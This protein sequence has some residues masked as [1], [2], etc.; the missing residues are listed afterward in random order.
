M[1]LVSEFA[2]DC[3]TVICLD[4]D[5]VPLTVTTALLV[6]V[7]VLELIALTVRVPSFVPL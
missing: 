2:P 6:L 1:V 5:A 7:E 3:I 4:K